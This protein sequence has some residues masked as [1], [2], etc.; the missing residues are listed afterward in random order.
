MRSYQEVHFLGD[1]CYVFLTTQDIGIQCFIMKGVLKMA[2]DP[3]KA[4]QDFAFRRRDLFFIHA[5]WR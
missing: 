1:D 3:N 2:I 4:L 5:T